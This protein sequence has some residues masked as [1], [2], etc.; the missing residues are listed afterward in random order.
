MPFGGNVLFEGM[1]LGGS[2]LLVSSE[3]VFRQG[4]GEPPGR[5]PKECGA[6]ARGQKI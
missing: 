4:K 5:T 3:V 6:I 2:C 1:C